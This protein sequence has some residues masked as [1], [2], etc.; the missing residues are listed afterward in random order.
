M[1]VIP[2][3]LIFIA[4]VTVLNV[5]V[6]RPTLRILAVRSQKIAGRA[7]EVEQ[8]QEDS[9]TKLKNYEAIL[10]E[11]RTAARDARGQILKQAHDEE[12]KILSS[13]QMQA[14]QAFAG[15]KR[16]IESDREVAAE[17][18][19]QHVDELTQH[20]MGRILEQKGAA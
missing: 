15:L 11:A 10:Q 4:T 1:T 17:R 12:S 19:S 13:A 8:L 16:Q 6:Y 9:Q 7:A 5:L 2:M 18:L 3:W 20:I 14:D